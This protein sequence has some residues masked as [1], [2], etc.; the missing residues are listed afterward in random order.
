MNNGSKSFANMMESPLDIPDAGTFQFEDFQTNIAAMIQQ[1]I[2]SFMKGKCISAEGVPAH[3]NS[4]VSEITGSSQKRSSSFNTSFS[5]DAWIMDSGATNHMCINYDLLVNIIALAKP[6]SICLP[7]GHTQEVTCIGDVH[8][9]SDIFLSSCLHINSFKYNLLSVSKL[10]SSTKLAV[11]FYPSFCAIQN[12]EQSQVLAVG[13]MIGGLYILDSNSFNKDV[14]ASFVSPTEL[15]SACC[16]NANTNFSWHYRLGHPSVTIT[17]HLDLLLNN[18]STGGN[19]VPCDV[20]HMSK[21]WRL[22]FPLS[23][24]QTSFPFQL[25][26]MDVW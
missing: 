15:S 17:K 18:S 12:I 23:S 5:S 2:E 24:I 13:R 7:D 22:V 6:V 1:G 19:N 16:N 10:I 4:V 20:C 11:E 9:S 21:Q 25:L 3:M 8:L 14:I 26:H